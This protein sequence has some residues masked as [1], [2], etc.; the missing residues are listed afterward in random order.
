[1][2]RKNIK[3]VC[4]ILTLFSLSSCALISKHIISA[5]QK[6]SSQALPKSKKTKKDHV[7]RNIFLKA[8]KE[9]SSKPLTNKRVKQLKKILKNKKSFI[10]K[11]KIKIILGHHFFLKKSYK[12][13]LSYYSQVEHYPSHQLLILREAK[14]YYRTGKYKKALKQVNFLLKADNLSSELSSE[15]YFLKLNITLKRKNPDKKELLE[16]YCHILNHENTDGTDNRKKAKD[17]IFSM[18]ETDI[19]DIKSESYIEPVKDPGVLSSR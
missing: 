6:A 2:R 13:A 18:D 9:V 7:E 14:I 12:K 15:L 3:F 4:F 8:K 5:P 17:I 10:S 19:L 16:I 1:M 11:Q